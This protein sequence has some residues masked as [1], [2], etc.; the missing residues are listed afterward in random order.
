[1][2][3]GD[4]LTQFGH[5]GDRERI[6][7]ALLDAGRALRKAVAG[8]SAAT[9]SPPSASARA[10]LPACEQAACGLRA[11][12]QRRH[13]LEA[14]QVGHQPRTHHELC[15]THDFRTNEGV[16]RENRFALFGVMRLLLQCSTQISV[17]SRRAVSKSI[18][19]LP[20]RAFLQ[21]ARAIVMDAAPAHIDGL[22][23]VPA[24]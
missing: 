18:R 1:M 23:L 12:R 24:S 6:E 17:N 13:A 21:R 2:E 10:V 20:F 8:T 5:H 22:D 9:G 14:F 19:T 11:P 3:F 15:P 16:C 7:F 4:I